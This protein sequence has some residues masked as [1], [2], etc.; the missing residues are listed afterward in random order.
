MTIHA[1]AGQ[2]DEAYTALQ[3]LRTEW[4]R[5]LASGRPARIALADGEDPRAV[6]AAARLQAEDLAVPYLI[7]S[8]VNILRAADV[9]GVEPPAS[10]RI[11]DI[12]AA[13][14]HPRY[15]EAINA[16]L[17]DKLPV[18]QID[19]LMRDPVQLAALL[20]H[21]GEVDGAVA[22]A[23]RPTGDVIRAGIRIIG[24]AASVSTVSSSFLMVL[25]DGA[26]IAYA[27][28]AVLPD[29]TAEQLADVAIATAATYRDLVD[30]EPIVA[31]LSFSTIGSAEHA[32]VEKVRRAT[33]IVR[34]RAPD[35]VV[36]GELQ[37]DAAYVAAVGTHKAPG[38]P[39]AGR[40][41]V[42]IFPNLD[43]GNIAYKITERIG[44]G[45]AIGPLLQGL[46]APLNDLSRGCTADDI[47]SL[48]LVSA[49]QS[50]HASRA[51]L[52]QGG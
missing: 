1:V 21:T 16:V 13:A 30:N 48:A 31:M 52:P 23:C 4:K 41:N 14:C 26:R 5:T 32:S 22:G 35:L 6:T 27:D 51:L 33:D 44:G 12:D 3:E 24:P 20:L 36:D 50:R 9:A 2:H 28:C 7:G 42:L 18:H 19:Q 25:P 43:A 39:V 45:K 10:V 34:R 37:F 11:V 47:V 8:S 38:S 40:A 15:R 46:N 49:L 29:P 17:G